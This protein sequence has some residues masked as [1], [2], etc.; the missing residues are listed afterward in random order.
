RVAGLAGA[1]AISAGGSHSLAVV[2]GLT[3]AQDGFARNVSGGWG[4]ADDLGG[5]YTVNQPFGSALSVSGGI[6]SMSPLAGGTPPP[7]NLMRVSARDVD[8]TFR[9]KLDKLPQGGTAWVGAR[10]RVDPSSHTYY[11]GRV[12]LDAG[13]RAFLVVLRYSYG[14]GAT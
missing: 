12:R 13:G 11:L 5:G 3:Y 6:G 4:V 2:Q 9:A 7:A 10:A 8:L 1:S 14:A